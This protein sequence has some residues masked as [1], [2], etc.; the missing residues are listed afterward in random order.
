VASG[1]GI[2]NPRA[3]S[4]R[5]DTDCPRFDQN[6]LIFEEKYRVAPVTRQNPICSGKRVFWL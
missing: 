1:F 4:N 5:D 6:I 2:R 3:L